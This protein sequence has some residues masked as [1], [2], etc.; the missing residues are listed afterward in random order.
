[1][2][3]LQQRQL[4]NPSAIAAATQ[5]MMNKNAAALRKAILPQVTAQGQ[6]TGQINAP[7]LMDQAYTSA[8]APILAQEQEAAMQQWLEANRLAGG[9]YPSGTDVGALGGFVSPNIFGGGTNP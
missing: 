3:Y 8:I 2:K 7:Y 6:E 9:L 4:E 5:Q 1:M